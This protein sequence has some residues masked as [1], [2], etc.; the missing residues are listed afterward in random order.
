MLTKDIFEKSFR[1]DN[2]ME[3]AQEKIGEID[4]ERLKVMSLCPHEIVVKYSNNKHK[5]IFIDE[6]YFCPACGKYLRCFSKNQ[7]KESPFK[8]SRV[9]YLNSI[10]LLEIEKIFHIIRNE[11]YSNIDFYYNPNIDI[12]EL[13]KTMEEL[14]NN[15]ECSDDKQKKLA[16]GKN[17]NN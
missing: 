11:M 6:C 2:E 12:Q 17:Y 16:K 1:L 3:K 10:S 14:L 8:N 5:K 13:S 15:H 4:L 9:I 7:I